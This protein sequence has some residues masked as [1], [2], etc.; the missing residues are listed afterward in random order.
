MRFI[1]L[2]ENN[3]VM[4]IRHGKSIIEGEIQSDVGEIGQIMQTDGSFVTPEPEIIIQPE[5]LEQKIERL[6]LQIQQDN[7]ITFEV[8]ATIYEELMKKGSV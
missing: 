4:S 8:L 1:R 6:E 3:K 5:T 2:D 7:L